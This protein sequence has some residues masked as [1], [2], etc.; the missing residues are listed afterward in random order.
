LFWVA[1]L[2]GQLPPG[3]D[4]IHQVVFIV[5]SLAGLLVPVREFFRPAARAH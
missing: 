4:H 3:K 1:H 5:L 2:V